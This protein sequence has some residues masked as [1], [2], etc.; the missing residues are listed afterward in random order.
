[1]QHWTKMLSKC[2]FFHVIFLIKE[3][4]IKYLNGFHIKMKKKNHFF[5]L[6]IHVDGAIEA[7]ILQLDCR[8]SHI[9]FFL[10]LMGMKA[11]SI[12]GYF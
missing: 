7:V 8:F 4:Y 9:F 12:Q 5:K 1:M 10:S 3:N 11:C 2:F 6:R